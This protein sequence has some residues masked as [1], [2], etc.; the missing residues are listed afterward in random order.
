M[1]NGPS[2]HANDTKQRETA[3]KVQSSNQRRC[4][5][6]LSCQLIPAIK[7]PLTPAAFELCFAASIS[8]VERSRKRLAAMSSCQPGFRGPARN[9]SV[10]NVARKAS[11]SKDRFASCRSFVCKV[12]EESAN[13]TVPIRGTRPSSDSFT[14]SVPTESQPSLARNMLDK[15]FTIATAKRSKLSRIQ[16][17]NGHL[18]SS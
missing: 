17:V 9:R 8:S 3:T 14:A 7:D 11:P 1:K 16:M 10:A 5:S 12:R 18:W 6:C 4:S 13:S 2:K 15:P